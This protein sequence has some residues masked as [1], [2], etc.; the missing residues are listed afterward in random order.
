MCFCVLIFNDCKNNDKSIEIL[1]ETNGEIQNYDLD[2]TLL[3]S[4]E[5]TAD[6]KKSAAALSRH[7]YTRSQRAE[8]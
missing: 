1:N 8:F 5:L 7:V 6:K 3:Q 4:F 2:A